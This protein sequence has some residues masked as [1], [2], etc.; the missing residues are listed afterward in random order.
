MICKDLCLLCVFAVRSSR[1]QVVAKWSRAAETV[2]SLYVFEC[3]ELELN[4]KCAPVEEDKE[5][6]EFDFTS[7][8]R[9]HTGEM[10]SALFSSLSPEHE[11]AD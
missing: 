10:A 3:I 4:L 1:L 11:T 6:V 8:I 2:P 5:S 7:P 9:L